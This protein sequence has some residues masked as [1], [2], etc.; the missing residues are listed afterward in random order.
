MQFTEKIAAVVH[1]ILYIVLERLFGLR[2]A[3]LNRKSLLAAIQAQLYLTKLL[4]ELKPFVQAY[5]HI[6][7][8]E[9]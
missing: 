4:S 8:T 9:N 2:M 7:D 1:D 5:L 3:G 6:I